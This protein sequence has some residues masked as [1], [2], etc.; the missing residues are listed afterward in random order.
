MIKEQKKKTEEQIKLL[1]KH[2]EKIDYKLWYYQTAKD[3]GTLAVH[4]K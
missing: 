2:K 1:K 3:A 4:K